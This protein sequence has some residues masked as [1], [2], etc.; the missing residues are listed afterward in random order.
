M[1]IVSHFRITYR[2]TVARYM[3]GLKVLIAIMLRYVLCV[4]DIYRL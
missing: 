3:Q 4:I 1:T 2:S